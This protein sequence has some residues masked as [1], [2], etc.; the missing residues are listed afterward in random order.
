MH[1][2]APDLSNM[3]FCDGHAVPFDLKDTRDPE[4]WGIEGWN[5]S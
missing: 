5:R 4:N 3:L 1:R 2:H